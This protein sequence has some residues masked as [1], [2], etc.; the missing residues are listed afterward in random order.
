M[1]VHLSISLLAGLA[2][3]KV[4]FSPPSLVTR[5][6]Q[7]SAALAVFAITV[8]MAINVGYEWKQI[9]VETIIGFSFIVTT[10][11][12]LILKKS[13]L[14]SCI[15]LVFTVISGV[16]YIN[17]EPKV[18]AYSDYEKRLE[19]RIFRTSLSSLFHS[20]EIVQE[21]EQRD[22]RFYIRNKVSGNLGYY[23][24]SFSQTGYDNGLR[25]KTNSMLKKVMAND[26][27]QR[28]LNFMNKESSFVFLPELTH[29]FDDLWQEQSSGLVSIELRN[30]G[31]N[32]SEFNVILTN[33]IWLIENE[34][35]FDGWKANICSYDGMCSDEI[36]A[37]PFGGLLRAW[38]LPVGNYSLYTRFEPLGWGYSKMIFVIGCLLL[39]FGFFADKIIGLARF[40]NRK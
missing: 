36:K 38:K 24:Q 40:L 12:I 39:I 10:A 34:L 27:S 21:S 8:K 7:L 35:Y 20:R 26:S 1:V 30:F 22:A 5:T 18:W 33:P 37:V 15:T 13:Y 11:A 2:L 28:L 17:H 9:H 4:C 3:H 16:Q 6:L 19:T 32:G 31:L 25:L 14:L 29:N 23:N